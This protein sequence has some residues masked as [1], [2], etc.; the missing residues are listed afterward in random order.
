GAGLTEGRAVLTL[1]F[2]NDGAGAEIGLD[3][4]VTSPFVGGRVRRTRPS[5]SHWLGRP[6]QTT[7]MPAFRFVLVFMILISFHLHRREIGPESIIAIARARRVDPRARLR[8]AASCRFAPVSAYR[9]APRNLFDQNY[10][11]W[12]GCPGQ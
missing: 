8:E 5:F 4:H 7:M 11:Y 12:E 2:E 9:S 10:C 6:Q 1:L 3:L